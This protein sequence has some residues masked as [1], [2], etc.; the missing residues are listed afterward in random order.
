MATALKPVKKDASILAAAP[1]VFSVL[2]GV[3]IYLMEK[4]D[5]YVRFHALQAILL[6]TA[7]TVIYTVLFMIIWVGAFFIVGFLCLPF[8]FLLVGAAILASIWLAYRAYQGEY[9]ELPVI[10]EFAARHI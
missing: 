4:E 6:H 9:F 2:I 5:R 10:G 1:Y 3:L 7:F 8:L